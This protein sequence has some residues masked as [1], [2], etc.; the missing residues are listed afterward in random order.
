[1]RSQSLGN[2]AVIIGISGDV[3]VFLQPTLNSLAAAIANAKRAGID[4]SVTEVKIP[5]GCD[6][7]PYR[8]R[9]I[10]K[11]RARYIAW[12][13]GG[14]LVSSNW[15]TE[16]VRLARK[17]R[18]VVLHPEVSFFF[19][20]PGVRRRILRSV[21]QESPAFN[22]SGL[23]W[24]N[25]WSS[26]VF[27][28]RS[29][30]AL[31]P[32]PGR[33]PGFG[34]ESWLWNCDLIH[35]GVIHKTV[36]GTAH[37]LRA[38]SKHATELVSRDWR[39]P[40]YPSEYFASKLAARG[41]RSEVEPPADLSWFA[42]LCEEASAF[43]PDLGL[44]ADS[45]ATTDEIRADDGALTPVFQR[46]LGI[47]GRRPDCLFVIHQLRRG[48]AELEAIA[49]VRAFR[50]ANP[51]ARVHFITTELSDS[52]WIEHLPKGVEVLPLGRE[53]TQY[54]TGD[55]QVRL[56]LKLLLQVEPRAV[57]VKHSWQ[58]WDIYKE[59]HT[60]LRAFSK[61]FASL[62]C[63][64]YAADGSKVSFAYSHLRHCWKA[65]AAVFCDNQ[66][67]ADHLEA[68]CGITSS[69]VL[70][71]PV[72]ALP[73]KRKARKREGPLRILWA[74]RLARQKNL[75]AL[76]AVAALLPDDEFHVYGEFSEPPPAELKLKLSS[77]PNLK[78]F[79]GF[80][81]LDSIATDSFDAFLYT[82][83]WDGLPN[84]LLEA[85]V[86]GLPVLAP[87]VGGIP[88]LITEE[89]GFPAEGADDYVRA[90]ESIRKDPAGAENRAAKL[91]EVIAKRH[92]FEAFTRKLS[93]TPGY[94]GP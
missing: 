87:K 44:S 28:E 40:V 63:I 56:L 21:D 69:R 68:I 14:D 32:F 33:K 54:F 93:S 3:P 82:S 64:D 18:N 59:T 83:L 15:I 57:H 20:G 77:T 19:G 62:Y 84:I 12:V 43:E 61:L 94:L 71:F 37:F 29:V 9:A 42:R 90:L 65:L 23:V 91:R 45:V 74:S 31:H 78:Y 47:I 49:H 36:L 16:S 22:P 79:G 92:S 30:L 27:A 10:S 8:N 34:H 55:D 25:Y 66:A 58:C 5:S 52:D 85:G 39:L 50:R 67:L 48:G 86:K 13:E 75:N 73:A 7:A 41:A 38:S 76:F 46:F 2:V 26:L 4:C 6:P 11:A 80:D 70:R 89:T 17:R 1:M 88:E 24:S 60:A 72:Q 51:K 35:R 81:G 53:T